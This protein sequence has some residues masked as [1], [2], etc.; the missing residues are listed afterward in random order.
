MISLCVSYGSV[1][2]FD[3]VYTGC[4]GCHLCYGFVRFTLCLIV[5]LWLVL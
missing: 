5:R 3:C 1:C 4:V 2:V